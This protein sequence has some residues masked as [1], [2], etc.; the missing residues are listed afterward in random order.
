MNSISKLIYKDKSVPADQRK[1]LIR[2]TMQFLLQRD[3]KRFSKQLFAQLLDEGCNLPLSLAKS[4]FYALMF[5]KLA[6]TSDTVEKD[7]L[8][9]RPPEALLNITHFQ[10]NE[11]I[12]R[13]LSY[14]KNPEEQMAMQVI[15]SLAKIKMEWQLDPAFFTKDLTY[16]NHRL[17]AIVEQYSE[18]VSTN[19]LSAL[20]IS[21]IRR[22]LYI[23]FSTSLLKYVSERNV[24]QSRFG[25]VPEVIKAMQRDHTVFCRLMDFFRTQTPYYIHLASQTFWRT[26]QNMNQEK[27]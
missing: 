27:I 1:Q 26:L 15:D 13:C 6:A 12:R 19:R 24:F 25:S 14:I 7:I 21:Q 16:F 11:A 22:R 18:S 23:A 8:I 17:Q 2:D 20:P 4:R 10:F 3:E 5:Q 9:K